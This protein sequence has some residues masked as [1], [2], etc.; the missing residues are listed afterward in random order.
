MRCK[1]F[2]VW[3]DIL[4]HFS[5]VVT[6]GSTNDERVVFVWSVSFEAPLAEH[7]T[8]YDFLVFHRG[9]FLGFPKRSCEI[10]HDIRTTKASQKKIP[11]LALF[12]G[13][14]E[15]WVYPE[16][17]EFFNNVLKVSIGE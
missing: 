7:L 14:F 3:W 1:T 6:L 2:L 5:N 16:V 11:M 12:N 13:E 4:V 9:G 8:S 10:A 15:T 17:V